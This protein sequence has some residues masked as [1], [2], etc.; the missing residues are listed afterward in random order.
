VETVPPVAPLQ[1]TN[2]QPAATQQS[3][4]PILLKQDEYTHL[5]T[6]SRGETISKSFQ[7]NGAYTALLL[8]QEGKGTITLTVRDQAGN[9]IV[10]ITAAIY[11]NN[12]NIWLSH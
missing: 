6:V 10:D 2:A 4:A 7:T 1:T 11:E 3:T 8:E 9:I 5:M 12:K